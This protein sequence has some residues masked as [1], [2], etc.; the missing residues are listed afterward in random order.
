M[1]ALKNLIVCGGGGLLLSAMLAVSGCGAAPSEE[2]TDY[3]AGRAAPIEWEQPLDSAAFGTTDGCQVFLAGET[4]T[5]AKTMQAEET[6]IR[7]FY[8]NEGVRYLLSEVGLGSGL[9]LV[10][11]IQTGDEGDLSY[12]MDQLDGTMAYSKETHD[13]WVWL[14]TYNQSLPDDQKLHVIGLDVDHQMPTAIRGLSLLV[15]D[16]VLPADSV[17]SVIANVKEN[18]QGA[19]GQLLDAMERHPDDVRAAFGD[20]GDWVVQ[21]CRNAEFTLAYYDQTQGEQA[22]KS[23]DLRDEAMM[24]N[25]LFAFGMHP[26]ETFFGEFGSEHVI[27]SA[28]DS[29][30]C[31][32][33]CN[34]FGMRLNAEDSP[35]K[36]KV[37]S[38]LYAYTEKSNPLFRSYSP[39]DASIDYAAF[40]NWF[41]ADAFFSL[42]EPGSPFASGNHL[43][44]QGKDPQAPTTDYVQKLLLLSD[45]P[46]CE[47]YR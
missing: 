14:R 21:F 44:K 28:C 38:I 29:D 3:L 26:Q 19:L 1:G 35:V 32:A 25:F 13:F 17:A 6:L 27:Q 2:V 37:C 7:F 11:Y 34:R 30:Y 5:K 41:G 42:D 20:A 45:S 12:Y 46:E 18:N 15:D 31:S 33:D 8:E 22:S 39:S 36:G 24:S 16:S 43:I 9:L 47:S 40:E 4:H 23:N 10:H